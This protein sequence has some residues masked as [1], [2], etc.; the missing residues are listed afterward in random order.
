MCTFLSYATNL[1][2][3]KLYELDTKKNAFPNRHALIIEAL[4]DDVEADIES[5]D[6]ETHSAAAR[7]APQAPTKGVPDIAVPPPSPAPAPQAAA[8]RVPPAAAPR[9]KHPVAAEPEPALRVLYPPAIRFVQQP[10]TQHRYNT[11]LQANSNPP[12]P[13]P[14]PQ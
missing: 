2:A 3:Y 4:A 9:H 7:H 12:P 10:P 11:R 5:D 6:L 8:P 13:A 1:K 14:P